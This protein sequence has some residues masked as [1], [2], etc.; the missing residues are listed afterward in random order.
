MTK[1]TQNKRYIQQQCKNCYTVHTPT[2]KKNRLLLNEKTNHNNNH[3]K[4]LENNVHKLQRDFNFK[5]VKKESLK[6]LNEEE[7]FRAKTVVLN[8]NLN[9]FRIPYALP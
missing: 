8:R 6:L 9:N 7:S 5:R 1:I 3:I 2:Y 4:A